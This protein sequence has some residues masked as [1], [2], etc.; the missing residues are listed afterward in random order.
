MQRFEQEADPDG[1][2]SPQERARRAQ[3]LKREHMQSIGKKGQSLDAWVERVVNRAGELTP[4]NI[5]RLR[6]LLPPAET[7]T[8]S[9]A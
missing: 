9:A 6:A 1:R 7:N 3:Q 4:E 2:L 5:E 8:D